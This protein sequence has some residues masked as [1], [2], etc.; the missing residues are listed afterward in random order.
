MS[1]VRELLAQ[2]AVGVDIGQLVNADRMISAV[3]QRANA[4][5]SV[6]AG[7]TGKAASLEVDASGVS[8]LE[9]LAGRAR[10]ALEGL[11]AVEGIRSLVNGFEDLA[12]EGGKLNDLSEKLGVG[13]TE[14]QQ[15]AYATSLAGVEADSAYAALGKLS[16]NVGGALAG[17][18]EQAQAFS[19]LGVSLKEADGSARPLIDVAQDVADSVASAG[20]EAEMAAR[21]TKVFGKA[22]AELIPAFKGGGQ[23]LRDYAEEF[24]ALGGGMGKD[25]VAKADEVDDQ[26]TRLKFAGKS[27]K[28]QVAGELLPM[29]VKFT[30]TLVKGAK[31]VMSFA[32]ET[33]ILRTALALLGTAGIGFAVTKLYGAAQAFGFV[34]ASAT[35]AGS[36]IKGVFSFGIVGSAVFVG[37]L[38]LVALF[39]DF[40]TLLE[41]GESVLGTF[42]DKTYGLG[43][44]AEFVREIKGAWSELS[45]AIGD[46]ALDGAREIL[47]DMASGILPAMLGHFVHIV[48]TVTAFVKTLTAAVNMA[49]RLSDVVGAIETDPGKVAASALEG[50]GLG[51][52]FRQDAGSTAAREGF[53]RARSA[54]G[55]ALSDAVGGLASSGAG[56]SDGAALAKRARENGEW[57][58][59]AL[60]AAAAGA[61]GGAAGGVGSVTQTVTNKIEVKGG[62]SNADTGKAIADALKPGAASGFGL[63][64]VLNSVT[65]R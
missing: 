27:L 60:G 2:F 23:A 62:P 17:G 10:S 16:R 6:L 56:G 22:G 31:Y 26:L 51:S 11:F 53:S 19:E 8:G 58:S 54:F 18:K 47:G 52:V 39:E 13:T 21:L 41:G 7:A 5:G 3:A 44:A 63:D 46:P 34:S 42:L 50:R 35:G 38:L 29:A 9:S 43:T 48:Q 20:S 64:S 4:L 57:A 40:Y 61:I 28:I 30:N 59:P 33:N 65:R 24:E 14:L 15:F 55:S 45:D 49:Q 12:A 1:G 25:F 37:T 32:R 36:A